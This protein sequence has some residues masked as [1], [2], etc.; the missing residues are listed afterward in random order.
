MQSARRR[1]DED[2]VS[3][4]DDYSGDRD[5]R[6]EHHDSIPATSIMIGRELHR[7]ERATSH[8]YRVLE[9][10]CVKR[11]R[12]LR[13]TADAVLYFGHSGRDAT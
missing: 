8:A 1:P 2:S 13:F 6:R 10:G 4:F 12:S 7:Y 3:I 11:R 5:Q 9:S